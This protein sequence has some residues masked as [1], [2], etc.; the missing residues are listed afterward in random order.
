MV[1]AKMQK[2]KIAKMQKYKKKENIKMENGKIV[3]SKVKVIIVIMRSQLIL[4]RC[5]R[6]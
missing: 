3:S 6:L 5:K 2:C 1:N 4:C